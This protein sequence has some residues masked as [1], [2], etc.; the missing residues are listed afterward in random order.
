MHQTRSYFQAKREELDRHPM[1]DG[2]REPL[3]GSNGPHGFTDVIGTIIGLAVVAVAL[4]FV[5]KAIL[6][7]F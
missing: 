6:A 1:P 2:A 4:S 7:A 5:A 3:F